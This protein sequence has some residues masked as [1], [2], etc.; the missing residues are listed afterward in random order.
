MLGRALFSSDWSSIDSWPLN[1]IS[2]KIG[3]NGNTEVLIANASS[4]F[5]LSFFS[6]FSSICAS[7]MQGKLSC[8]IIDLQKKSMQYFISFQKTIKFI[9]VKWIFK[10][11][12]SGSRISARV[13]DICCFFVV[14]NTGEALALG[15]VNTSFPT[16]GVVEKVRKIIVSGPTQVLV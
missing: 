3:H 9:R 11:I 14:Q 6:P 7:A 5:V 12:N 15:S 2:R 16:Y 1:W 10:L 4:S 8:A 13:W